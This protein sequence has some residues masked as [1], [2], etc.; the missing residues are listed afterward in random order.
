MIALIEEAIP[1]IVFVDENNRDYMLNATAEVKSRGAYVIGIADQINEL[2]DAY[3]PLVN[4]SGSSR[5]ISSIIPCQL[6]AYFLSTLNGHNPDRPRNLAKS[7]TV[8]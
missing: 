8:R 1:V 5:I 4:T 6:L 2:F 7:V 3:I